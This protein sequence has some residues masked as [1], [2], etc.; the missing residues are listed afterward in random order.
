VIPVTANYHSPK[1]FTLN[2][3]RCRNC[4]EAYKPGNIGNSIGCRLHQVMFVRH[5]HRCD[6][7]HAKGTLL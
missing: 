5:S 2:D 3:Q 4:Q 6:F 7:W 1:A